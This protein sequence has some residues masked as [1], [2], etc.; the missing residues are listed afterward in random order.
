MK[1]HLIVAF[2][3]LS[4]AI[5]SAQKPVEQF[6][7]PFS[8]SYSIRK[9]QHLE[10]KTYVEKILKEQ[11]DASL[12]KFTPDFF[13]IK[14]YESSLY[15]YRQRLGNYFGYIPPKS[16]RGRMTKFERVG[17]D[18]YSVVYRAWIEVAEGLNAYGIFMVPLNLKKKAPLI[19]AIHGGGG[20]PEAICGLDTRKPY[21]NFG[22]EAVKRG[23]IVWA[24]GLTML[25]DYSGDQAIPGVSREVLDKQLKLMGNSII[26]LEI[27]KIIEST[28]TLMNERSEIDA[29]N[30]GMTGLSWGGFF[31]MYSTALCPFV[32]AAA[33]S[34]N[35]RDTRVE[36][37]KTLNANSLNGLTKPFDG[38]GYFQAI[39]MICPRPCLVQLGEKD[40]V[41]KDMDGARVE[42]ERSAFFYKKLN[43]PEK[44]QYITHPGGHEFELDSIFSFFAKYLK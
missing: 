20:N 30:I 21:H 39:G 32:K 19:V 23:Y 36:L 31:T 4:G 1:K 44:F 16:I 17:E 40:E 28:R 14:D 41:F 37:N 3:M 12:N 43:M 33:I 5:V 26:G 11:I 15:P 25:S 24:P 7:E 18:K 34:G 22:Y 35:F 9:E 8:K 2:L 42:A 10:V 29:E 27:H 38:F 6:R 13:S